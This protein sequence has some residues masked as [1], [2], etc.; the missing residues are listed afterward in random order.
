[1]NLQESDVEREFRREVRE[2]VRQSL[3]SD[4][5]WKVMRFMRLEKQD[6]ARWHEILYR[7][8]WAAPAWPKEYGGPGWTPVQRKIFEDETMLAGAPRLMPHTNMIGPVLQHFGT[9]AQKKRFLP[10]MLAMQDWWCQGYSEPGS[11]SDLA[12]LQ[13]RAVRDGDRYIVNGQKIWTSFANWADWMFC[14]VR[15]S[16]EGK[17]QRGITFLLIDMKTPGITVR[18]IRL[19]NG[20]IDLNQVFFDDVAVP[21]E[22]RVHEENEGWTVAKHLLGHE[23]TEVALVGLNKRFLMRIKQ[24]AQSTCRLGRPL[25]ED[26]RLRDRIARLEMRLTAHE[27][28]LLRTL[29]ADV[30]GTPGGASVS[31]LK[32]QGST[33]NQDLSAL[34]LEC[35]G[36]QALPYL[37]AARNGWLD[38][39]PQPGWLHGLASVYVDARRHTIYGGTT[40]VQKNIIGNSLIGP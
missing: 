24:I 32:L 9:L 7:K 40:E 8:G 3:P 13:T 33:L 4:L 20:D 28:L 1:V 38:D 25:L 18:P 26:Q 11:G 29:S 27:W 14:L 16:S 15:T 30:S 34:L 22:N 12:S 19:L 5:R 31:I 36:P 10:R 39:A 35:A 6:I 23:R 37:D 17:P 21:L 2:F